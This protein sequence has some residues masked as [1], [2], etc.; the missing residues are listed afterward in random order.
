MVLKLR[1]YPA[2]QVKVN[3]QPAGSLPAREDGL[4]VMPVPEGPV[5]ITVDWTTT[6]DVVTGRWLS[7]LAL[8]LMALVLWAERRLNAR[9]FAAAQGRLTEARLS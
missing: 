6:A 5:Q 2:W 4:M 3:G 1:T 9:G 7:M 8:A